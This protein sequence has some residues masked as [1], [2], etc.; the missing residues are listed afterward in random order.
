VAGDI[1]YIH[2]F[3]D[4]VD[5][6]GPLVDAWTRAGFRIN[7]FDLPGHGENTGGLQN[8]LNCYSFGRLAALALEVERRTREDAGRPLILAGWSTGGL[9]AIRMAQEHVFQDR[10]RRPV[11]MILFAPAVSVYPLVGAYGVVTQ[12]TLTRNPDPPH[13]GAIRLWNRSILLKP[14]FALRMIGNAWFRS[15]NPMPE[16]LPTLIFVGGE[17]DDAYACSLGLK[18]WAEDQRARG[19]KITGVVFAGAYHELH[20]EA[21]PVGREVR[22]A[23]AAFAGAVATGASPDALDAALGACRRF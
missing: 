9:L 14:L 12:G 21:A 16:D 19:G 18:K 17:S 7:A 3:A 2:G 6:H 4:R 11:G 22:A 5:H 8:N 20:N 10:G 1:L 15:G 13:K 23:S